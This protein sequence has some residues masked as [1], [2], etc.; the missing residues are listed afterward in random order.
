MRRA[1]LRARLRDACGMDWLDAPVSGGPAGVERGTLVVMAGGEA[2][3]FAKVQ[4]V[5]GSYAAR[6]TL[7]GPSGAGQSTKLI[8]QT[9]VAAHVKRLSQRQRSSRS[10]PESMRNGSRRRS[11]AGE[12]TPSC[13][14]ILCRV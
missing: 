5:V 2:A 4:E 10:T 13:C 11:P 1:G 14:K 8:N 7:M 3:P 12:R 9:L 6:F